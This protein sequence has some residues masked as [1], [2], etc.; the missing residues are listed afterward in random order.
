MPHLTR[1][2]EKAM[3]AKKNQG[4]T[5][6]A[7]N[8]TIRG[9]IAGIKEALRQRR[10]RKGLERIEAEKLALEKEKITA[11]RL[12]AELEVEQARETVAMQRA[13]TQAEFR[14]IEAAKRERKIAPIRKRF[15]EIAEVGRKIG[16]A[17][18]KATRP[19]KRKKKT[20][21]TGFFGI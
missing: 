14:K 8:P 3:F 11:K 21:D 2:Q 1:Q 17:T 20:E 6:S 4:S 9:R 12:K 10:E 16:K 13:E 5:R 18:E 7:T 19:K 15:K